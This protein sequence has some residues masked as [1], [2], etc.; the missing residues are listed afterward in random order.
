MATS[1]RFEVSLQPRLKKL[2]QCWKLGGGKGDAW[3]KGWSNPLSKFH[4]QT[5]NGQFCIKMSNLKELNKNSWP[6]ACGLKKVT[7]GF[8]RYM[9]LNMYIYIYVYTYIYIYIY[10]YIHIYIHIYLY[11]IYIQYIRL[12]NSDGLWWVSLLNKWGYTTLSDTP[13]SLW[14]VIM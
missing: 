3:T 6:L 13:R 5:P 11:Y 2:S 10:M 1:A 8:C 4:W 14:I 7:C 9:Y 12:P